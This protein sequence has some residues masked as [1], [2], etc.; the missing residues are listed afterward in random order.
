MSKLLSVGEHAPWV[1]YVP[2]G[3]GDPFNIS[4]LGGKPLLVALLGSLRHP[5]I[6]TVSDALNEAAVAGANILVVTSDPADREAPPAMRDGVTHAFDANTEIAATFGACPPEGGMAAYRPQLIVLDRR[7]QVA[8]VL[9]PAEVARARA[10]L[11]TLADDAVN[12]PAPVLAMPRLFEP[13]FCRSLID[14]YE[15]GDSEESGFMRERSGRT[16]LVHDADFKRRRDHIIT[17][18]AAQAAIRARIKDRLLP[19]IRR[20]FQYEATRIERYLVA[21]YDAESGGHFRAHRDNTTRGTMHRRFAVTINLNADYDGGDLR[22]PEFGSRTYRAEPG[23]AVV[24]SCS[25]LHEATPVT[26][27]RRYACLPF[28]YDDAAAKVREANVANIDFGTAA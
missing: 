6:A 13:E 14:L 23:G 25:L 21:A 27:G 19:A 15:G 2:L 22:F 3:G 26:R 8:A 12:I 9:P 5:V 28:L 4:R 1:A 20:A 11:A 7:L 10:L 16:T 18:P 17:D 24:F